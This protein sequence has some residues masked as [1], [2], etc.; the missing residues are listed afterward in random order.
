[1]PADSFEPNPGALYNV[2]GNVLEWAEDCRKESNT[3]G[4]CGHDGPQKS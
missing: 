2:H 1:M 3:T 4:G